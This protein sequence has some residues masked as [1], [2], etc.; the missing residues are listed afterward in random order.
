MVSS[1]FDPRLPALEAA[2][3]AA[4]KV[5]LGY[6]GKVAAERK[7]DLS[8][9]TEA[10]RA[11]ERYLVERLAEIEPAARVLGEEGTSQ[12]RKPDR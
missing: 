2:V 6:F 12:A 3:R 4:G 7:L 8:L 10:D 5:A 1:R 9:V 11:V